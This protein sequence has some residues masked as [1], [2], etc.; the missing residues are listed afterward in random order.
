MAMIA[1]N[2]HDGRKIMSSGS[3]SDH[4]LSSQQKRE[5]L[6]QLVRQMASPA[7]TSDRLSHGQAALWFAHQ[8]AP[9]SWT[10]HVVFSVR[11]RSAVD[12][13]IMRQ[14]LQFLL[15]RHAILR[16]T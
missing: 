4:S 14:A 6:A 11:I 2:A 12:E 10:Y 16:T 1:H 9:Q 8:L 7:T 15:D 13:S 5:L 3:P